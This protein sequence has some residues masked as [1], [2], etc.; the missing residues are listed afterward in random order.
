MESAN[1]DQHHVGTPNGTH[2]NECIATMK[3]GTS[4]QQQQLSISNNDAITLESSVTPLE[5][6]LLLSDALKQKEALSP[7]AE[8]WYKSMT[9]EEIQVLEQGFFSIVYKGCMLAA[10]RSCSTIVMQKRANKQ[11]KKKKRKESSK[12]KHAGHRENDRFYGRDFNHY[13]ASGSNTFGHDQ[14]YGAGGGFHDDY[15]RYRDDNRAL[16]PHHG[17][18]RDYYDSRQRH[19]SPRSRERWEDRYGE[20][21]SRRRSRSDSRSRHQRRS[22][23]SRSRSLEN[24]RRSRNWRSNSLSPPRRVNEQFESRQRR[25]N[26]PSASFHSHS[27]D[28]H[29]QGEATK[30]E[31]KAKYRRDSTHEIDHGDFGN[32]LGEKDDRTPFDSRRDDE[33]PSRRSRRGRSEK[34]RRSWSDRYR[35]HSPTGRRSSSAS[36]NRDTRK[37]RY[38]GADKTLDEGENKRDERKRMESRSRT[39]NSKD[40]SKIKK[41]EHR[42]SHHRSSRR[43]REKYGRSDSPGKGN[44]GTQGDKHRRSSTKEAST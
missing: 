35:S 34:E 29:F 10:K 17:N 3:N 36:L 16:R 8:Q 20:A 15:D 44:G 39:E 41:N 1:G 23:R 26:S 27:H 22:Y 21:N 28:S 4:E 9:P 2:P 7:E 43:S 38:A 32:R 13:R 40:D 42:H 19:R 11:R 6:E 37:R 18:D 24:S 31:N 14:Y 5:I 33:S 30:D 12:N 25:F